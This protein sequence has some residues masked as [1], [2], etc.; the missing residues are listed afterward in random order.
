MKQF[1][2]IAKYMYYYNKSLYTDI[3]LIEKLKSITYFSVTGY[4]CYVFNAL[5]TFFKC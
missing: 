1:T 3:S 5:L 4:T 2:F